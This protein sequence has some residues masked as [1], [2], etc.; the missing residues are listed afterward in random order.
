MNH[1]ATPRLA[2]AGLTCL[3]LASCEAPRPEERGGAPASATSLSPRATAPAKASASGG[4]LSSAASSAPPAPPK[5]EQLTLLAGGDVSFG[6][7]RGQ[8][9]LRE[10][11]RDDFAPLAAWLRAA[12][13]RFVNLECPLS[14]Q[15]GLTRSPINKLVFTG[16]P[17]GAD[18]LQRADI[19]V[20]SLANNH[21]WD[22]GHSGLLQTLKNLER[23]HIAYVG[24]G[25]SQQRA[26]QPVIV[27][28]KGWRIAFVAVTAVWN[29]N[30]NPHPGRQFVADAK[31]E[32]LLAAVRAA[33]ATRGVDR[34]VLSYHGGDEYET[35]PYPAT[36]ALL[37]DAI[38]AGADAVVAHH[39]HVVREIAFV[40][41]KP[42]L[43]SLGNL[44]MRM[45]TG[46]PWTEYGML[47][48][49]RFDRAGGTALSV[50][51][52]RIFG[53]E[54]IPL[55]GDARRLAFFRAKLRRLLAHGAMTSPHTSATLA[56]FQPDGCMAVE[57]TK[58]TQPTRRK[59]P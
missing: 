17:I 4:A 51:P 25:R 41:G 24:A 11:K 53:L 22:Y 44:L 2:L 56:P 34:V 3:L 23:T 31:R 20:V 40:D 39:P 29:Q 38:R 30:L 1:R 37:A 5:S 9:L 54:P 55:T 47:A 45:V 52:L 43:F 12:D 13:L 35:M 42:I 10:P 48:R 36:R 46:K 28:K 33:R 7:M 8:R 14:E 57:V 15:G 50:C 27:E 49:L 58:T 32:R 59:Q 26:Y 18:A 19:D 16:P 21:A 6:R